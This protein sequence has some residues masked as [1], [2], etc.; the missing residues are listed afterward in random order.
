MTE[1]DFV[2]HYGSRL[3]SEED[4]IE[5]EDFH[6]LLSQT[7]NHFLGTSWPKDGEGLMRMP[8]LIDFAEWL[9]KKT[10]E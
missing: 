5:A 6:T 1:R 2:E 7:L 3:S 8:T 9:E 4:I 10:N